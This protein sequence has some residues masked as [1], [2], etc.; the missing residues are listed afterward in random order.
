[1][2]MYL[3]ICTKTYTNFYIYICI[4]TCMCWM[5]MASDADM[6]LLVRLLYGCDC[7]N[8]S[9]YIHIY[10]D[11]THIFLRMRKYMYWME[12]A[13]NAVLLALLLSV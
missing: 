10:T 6:M 7:V 4:R 8:E 9:A 1:M 2:C 3:Y 13:N 12:M 11:I 5:Y